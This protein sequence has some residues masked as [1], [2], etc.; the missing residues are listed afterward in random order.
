MSPHRGKLSLWLLLV[1]MP[2]L[3][4]YCMLA[5]KAVPASA[6]KQT[7]APAHV[8]SIR[9]AQWVGFCGGCY[10]GDELQVSASKVTLFRNAWRECQ[11]RD[12]HKYRDFRVDSDISIK[13]WKEL[14]QLV[15]KTTLRTLPDS[16]GCASCVDGV[17]ELIEVKFSD[18]TKKSVQFP[19][20]AP[21]KELLS[22]HEKLSKLLHRLQGELVNR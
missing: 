12:P 5:Q 11:Q 4:G 14:A 1:T 22:L 16:T 13:H 8:A 19:A 17:D 21:P 20:G 2:V 18:A 9:F 7:A 6:N 3:A 10:C 15:D